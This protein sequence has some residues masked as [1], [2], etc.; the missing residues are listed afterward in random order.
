[1]LETLRTTE[2]EEFTK[3]EILAVLEK[4]EHSK[5]PG[6]ESLNSDVLLHTSKS[7]P[8]FFIEILNEC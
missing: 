7:F 3:K 4:F 2:G 5:A 8:N 6:E 1:M